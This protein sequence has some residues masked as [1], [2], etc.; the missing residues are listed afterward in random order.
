MEKIKDLIKFG[1]KNSGSLFLLKLIGIALNYGVLL[2]ILNFYQFEGNGE[3]AKFV[4]LSRGIKVFVVFGLDYLIVKQVAINEGLNKEKELSLFIVL[5]LNVALFVIIFLLINLFIE[6]DILLLFGVVFL[7]FWR[8]IGHFFRGKDN[9]VVYGFFEFIIFQIT[10]FLG[11]IVSNYI[12]TDLGFIHSVIIVN[13]I[14]SVIVLTIVLTNLLRSFSI[15][16]FKKVCMDSLKSI[17]LIYKTA[18]HFVF[19]NSINIF[20]TSILYVI[21][22]NQYSNEILGIYDTVLRISQ[23][24]T[25][26]LIATNGRVLTLAA[27]YFNNKMFGE[28]QTYIKNNTKVLMVLSSIIFIGVIVF[29]YGFAEFYNQMLHDYWPLFMFLITA[30][31]INNWAGPVGIVLQATGHEK[32]FNKITL[33]S[34]LYLLIS[35]YL[36][37]MHFSITIV[38]INMMLYLILLNSLALNV[39]YKKLKIKPF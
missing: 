13:A 33:I 8:F 12:Y 21:I 6:L 22:Q 27:K 24:V 39:Q 36:F 7:S 3:F 38:G 2:L 15:S 5:F 29:Y 26:P 28:L 23:I 20:A 37:T 35:T 10:V 16:S 32:D 17:H 4:A 18:I 25:L 30:Q 34:A 19:T 31:L 14:A 11:I 1:I 9:M